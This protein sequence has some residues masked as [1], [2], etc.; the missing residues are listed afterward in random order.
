MENI[1]CDD[2]QYCA[3]HSTISPCLFIHQRINKHGESDWISR[4]SKHIVNT[5]HSILRTMN[6]ERLA[7]PRKTMWIRLQFE[8]LNGNRS[9]G[10]HGTT[11]SFEQ[12][13]QILNRHTHTHTYT[14]KSIINRTI[15]SNAIA[16]YGEQK[17]TMLLLWWCDDS[18]RCHLPP[19][20]VPHLHLVRSSLGNVLLPS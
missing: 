7:G 6:D 20:P 11:T 15:A 5:I 4:Q 14:V 8:L 17:T 3:R 1:E 2:I 18:N 9:I 19:F 16:D 10:F 12:T 13:K